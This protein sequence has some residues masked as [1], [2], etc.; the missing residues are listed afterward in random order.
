MTLK[1]ME[2]PRA[3]NTD[4][5]P[6]DLFPPWVEDRSRSAGLME[7]VAVGSLLV[8]AIGPISIKMAGSE[9]S[10]QENITNYFR[11]Y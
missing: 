10:A 5:R 4:P 6:E 11:F 8:K 3:A 7:A 9:R 2:A 1:P